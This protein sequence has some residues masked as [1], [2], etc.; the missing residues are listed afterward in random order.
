M[1]VPYPP[2]GAGDIHSRQVA[3]KLDTVLGQAV[4]VENRAGA[5]G[6]IGAE[7]V[8]K[9]PPD[10]YTI[11]FSSISIAINQ[12][13]SSKLPFNVLTDF[14]PISLTLTSQS[15]LVVRPSLPVANVK[16]LI[17]Y[18]KANPGK[19]SFAST[20]VGG[21]WLAVELLKSLTGVEMLHVPYKGDGPAIIDL[22]GGRVDMFATTIAAVDAYHRAGKVR[23]L[24]VTSRKRAV[25]LPDVPT[26]EEAGVPGYEFESWFGFLAP[27]GTPRP[28]IN[29]LNAAMVQVISMPDVQRAITDV[30]L[31]PMT[32]TPEQYQQ[33]IQSDVERFSRIVKGAGIRPE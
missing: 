33:R 9:S 17:A 5:S 26:M 11:V 7:Y 27:V 1:V 16:E 29:R 25:S 31:I 19:L 28:I 30:G 2:G 10:G 3:E 20:G 12:A 32:S 21:P 14:A 24:A 18:G 15:L 22:I 6:N 23:G 4:I 8:A 13:V